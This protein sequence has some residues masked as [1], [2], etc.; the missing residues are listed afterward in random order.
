M[1]YRKH[2]PS[3]ADDEVVDSAGKSVEAILRDSP[4]SQR[5]R[6]TLVR[7]CKATGA[8]LAKSQRGLEGGGCP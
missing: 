4:A 3:F 6:A 2:L 8:R 1:I 5:Q 7:R